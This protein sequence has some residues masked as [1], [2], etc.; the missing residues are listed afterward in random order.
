MFA[1]PPTN[2]SQLK[3]L[4]YEKMALKHLTKQGLKLLHKNYH[5][6]LGEIDLV[7]RDADYI[8]FTEVRFRENPDY[9]NGLDSVT[10]N[11]QQKLIKTAQYYLINHGLYEKIAARFDV[12]S[13]CK[14]QGKT[15]LVW[16]KNAF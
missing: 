6:R 14:S 2:P 16:V 12:V 7:M 15:E 4:H 13:I 11:K 9:G 1:K 3:G 8:V 10:K 5:C